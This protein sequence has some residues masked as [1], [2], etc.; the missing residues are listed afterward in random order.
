MKNIF[1][2]AENASGLHGFNI[3]L[4]FSGKRE[5]F[6][7]HRHNVLL[8]NLLKDGIRLEELNRLTP[9]RL[10]TLC[11][12]PRSSAEKLVNSVRHLNGVIANYLAERSCRN[13]SGAAV[14]EPM[15]DNVCPDQAA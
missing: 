10:C 9:R 14:R 12:C 7:F 4:C 1:I 8:F 11:D 5:F 3:Y 13:P 6:R 2:Y 15:N